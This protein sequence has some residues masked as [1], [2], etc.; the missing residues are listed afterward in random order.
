MIATEANL[1][2]RV[3]RDPAQ[4]DKL[5]FE[6]AINMRV[7]QFGDFASG[8]PALIVEYVD[9]GLRVPR[10]VQNNI[11]HFR[12]EILAVQHLSFNGVNARSVTRD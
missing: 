8:K 12:V 4:I 10:A 9:T 3:G 1:G 6:A 2:H 5:V 7:Q 11:R